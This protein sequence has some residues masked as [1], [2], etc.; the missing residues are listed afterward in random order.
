MNES[1]FSAPQLKRGPLGSTYD[2]A[3]AAGPDSM[4]IHSTPG[5]LKRLRRTASTYFQRTF[6]TP[7]K[8][9][10]VFVKI[11]SDPSFASASVAVEQVVFPPKHLDSL[12]SS[13]Q[14]PLEYGSGWTIEAT[15]AKECVELLEATL[16]DWLDFFFLPQPKRFLMYADHDE[17]TT[18]FAARKGS[19]SRLTTA[20]TAAGVE[21]IPDYARSL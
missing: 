9:L 13:H 17:Y 20:L 8:R 4:R 3:L 5:T 1:F 2:R 7:L 21:E 12:L 18:L 14:L 6:R 11:L 16:A 19:L 10:P 15:G